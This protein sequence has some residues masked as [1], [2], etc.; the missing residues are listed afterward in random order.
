MTQAEW[1]ALTPKE[2]NEM[3]KLGI[4]PTN[5][6]SLG[7]PIED[8]YLDGDYAKTGATDNTEWGE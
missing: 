1:L 4:L 8:R 6:E 3:R 2:R 7:K 5:G